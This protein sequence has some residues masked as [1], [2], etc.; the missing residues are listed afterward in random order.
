MSSYVREVPTAGDS[1]VF[2]NSPLRISS[3]LS[4]DD[5]GAPLT[6]VAGAS[7]EMATLWEP[8]SAAVAVKSVTAA[9]AA[10]PIPALMDM[11]VA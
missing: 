10:V 4:S 3:T 6:S 5:I 7:M 8:S 1:N 2:S 11:P 9:G